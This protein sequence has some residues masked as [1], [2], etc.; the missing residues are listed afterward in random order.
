M[1]LGLFFKD[2]A[3]KSQKQEDQRLQ[4]VVMQSLKKNGEP[5]NAR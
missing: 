2:M 5:V 3:Q 1:T 4:V